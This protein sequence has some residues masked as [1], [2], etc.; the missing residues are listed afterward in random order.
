M[1]AGLAVADSLTDLFGVQQASLR[2]LASLVAA[3]TAS[4]EVFAEIAHAVAHVTGS[5]LV[6]AADEL[7]DGPC[8]RGDDHQ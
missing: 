7:A 5:A 2:R 3:G 4:S 8:P 6:L 1:P